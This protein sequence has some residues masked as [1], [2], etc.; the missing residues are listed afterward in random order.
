MKSSKDGAMKPNLPIGYWL[1]HTDEVLT[2][3]INHVQAENGVSR[4]QW[5]ILNA[6]HELGFTSQKQL[7][8]AMQ[9]F[10][11]EAELE[12][13]LAELSEQGWLV[14]RENRFQ[15]SDEGRARHQIILETQKKVRQSA[16]Q[17]IS[18]E[19]YTTVINVLQRI[20]SNLEGK[21]G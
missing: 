9:T 7:L 1:K 19:D 8:E 12:H 11:N 6:I 17:G 15:L 4:S 2:K 14:H 21:D 3:H 16:M 18:E 20:V 13:I 10:V 5:Q